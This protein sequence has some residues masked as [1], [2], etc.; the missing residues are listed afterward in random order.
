LS[1]FVLLAATALLYSWPNFA[2]YAAHG[3]RFFPATSFDEDYYAAL[4]VSTAAGR[5][6]TVNP[7]LGRTSPSAGLG[8]E[9]LQ[10]VPRFV[11]AGLVRLFGL[12]L[13]FGI[14]SLVVPIFV[15]LFAYRLSLSLA[16][17][18]IWALASA[19]GLLLL[20]FYLPPLHA[21]ASWL[22]HFFSPRGSAEAPFLG[23]V[24]YTRRY[25]PALSAVVFYAFLLVHWRAAKKRSVGL[26]IAAGLLGGLLFYCYIFFALSGLVMACIWAAAAF[27]LFRDSLRSAIAGVGVQIFVAAPFFY[28]MLS[29]M[30]SFKNGFAIPSR[31]PWWPWT[32]ILAIVVPLIVLFLYRRLTETPVWLL[33]VS[34]APILCMNV[35]VLTGMSVEPWHYDAYIVV[36]L[37]IFVFSVV[38][39]ELLPSSLVIGRVAGVAVVALAITAGITAQHKTVR[40]LKQYST[41]IAPDRLRPI[42]DQ[43][44]QKAGAEDV[45]LVGDDVASGPWVVAATGRQVFDSFYVASFPP[46]DPTEYRA[47]ALCYYWLD[48]Y[49]Q[50]TFL[51]GPAS[52][53]R[54]LLYATEGFRYWFYPRLWT[55]EIKQA[56]AREFS[57]CLR[58]PTGC[59]LPRYRADWIIESAQR[60]LDRG[61]LTQLFYVNPVF[62]ENGYSLAK[63]ARKSR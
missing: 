59:C 45:I 13:A 47:R 30:H 8:T 54:S 63:L 44:R 20:P 61:R 28:L 29:G 19:C 11:T 32:D 3:T 35:Q 57:D 51:A 2:Y 39:G 46:A 23:G 12:G 10:F 58:N 34:V 25:N 4:A 56:R 27:I 21:T 55:D 14:I 17:S 33:A 26:A 1:V 50:N 16:R 9:G 6:L 15:F 18:H 5:G 36:P 52:E 43:I 41:A 31:T 49:D 37:G 38:C 7:L 40:S 24:R 62:S 42:F 53:A 60:P 48:G 22:I